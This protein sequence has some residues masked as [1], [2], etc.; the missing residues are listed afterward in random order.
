MK[1]T[2]LLDD[3]ASR[4]ASRAGQA[5]HCLNEYPGYARNKW[6][7]EARA[8][9]LRGD[10]QASFEILPMRWDGREGGCIVRTG[11]RI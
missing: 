2:F 10:P 1:T 6:R 7:E 3:L 4:L 11:A 8:D 5:W 9:V